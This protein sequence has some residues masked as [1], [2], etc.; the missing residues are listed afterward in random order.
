[1]LIISKYKDYYDYLSSVFGIDDK[2][3]L[4]RR[5]GCK[6]ELKE[7]QQ[8]DLYICGLRHQG[9]LFHGEVLF[10]SRLLTIPGA[11]EV[12]LHTRYNE[13]Y[14]KYIQFFCPVTRLNK[15]DNE[16]INI[17]LEPEQSN[18]NKEINCPIVIKLRLD[19]I[20]KYPKLIDLNFNKVLSAKEI[21]LQLVDWLSPKEVVV[22]NRTDKEK[23]LSNGFDN[24]HSFRNT[25]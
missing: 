21:Y 6:I 19:T 10:G 8:I 5:E 11:K 7:N 3:I 24:I 15:Y 2:V 18:V 4:D 1:V 13:P 14:K 12:E 25:K 23:L 16:C 20:I 9:F 22:D 17:I